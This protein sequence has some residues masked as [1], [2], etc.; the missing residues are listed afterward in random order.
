MRK[1]ICENSNSFLFIH[2]F[3]QPPNISPRVPPVNLSTVPWY[4]SW[5]LFPSLILLKLFLII[6]TDLGVF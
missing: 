3:G 1:L 4:G 6:K 5:D 2:V